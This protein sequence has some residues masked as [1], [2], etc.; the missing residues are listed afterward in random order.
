MLPLAQ[1][2]VSYIF[3]SIFGL[4]FPTGL[5]V[6]GSIPH[7][8]IIKALW[9]VSHLVWVVPLIAFSS[10]LPSFFSLVFFF[11]LACF[12]SLFSCPCLFFHMKFSTNLSSFV[13]VV[14]I[15]FRSNYIIN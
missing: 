5:S 2:E 3:H 6:H 1:T 11:F 8:L 12:V 4:F 13:N 14:G 9:Y 10:F 7:C 15:L